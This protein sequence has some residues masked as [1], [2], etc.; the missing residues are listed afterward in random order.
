[1]DLPQDDPLYK[2]IIEKKRILA[3][4]ADHVSI[5]NFV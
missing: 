2:A 3:E 1:M 5:I 4:N